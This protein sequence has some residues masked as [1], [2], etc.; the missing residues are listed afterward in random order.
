MAISNPDNNNNMISLF[1]DILE[2]QIELATSSF[3]RDILVLLAK[4]S[5]HY[6]SLDGDHSFHQKSNDDLMLMSLKEL[7]PVCHDLVSRCFKK[8]Q[9]QLAIGDDSQGPDELLLRVKALESK[10]SAQFTPIKPA[11][12]MLSR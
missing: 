12:A 10:A 11:R 6:I 5:Y 3:Q 4:S 9:L 7:I 2:M 1:L 8:L